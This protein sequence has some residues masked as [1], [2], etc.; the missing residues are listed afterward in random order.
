MSR[1]RL[2]IVN[3]LHNVVRQLPIKTVV[4]LS[5]FNR[6]R[7]MSPKLEGSITCETNYLT[8]FP[9]DDSILSPFVPGG[10][11]GRLRS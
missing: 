2:H 11:F 10:L 5:A 3:S 4:L 1:D 9:I 8:I 6:R 7:A